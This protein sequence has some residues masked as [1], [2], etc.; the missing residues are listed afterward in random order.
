MNDAPAK[1]VEAVFGAAE[2][3]DDVF[4]AVND[5]SKANM[6]RRNA[7][8]KD[9]GLRICDAF[10]AARAGA[11][12]TTLYPKNAHLRKGDDKPLLEKVEG[13]VWEKVAPRVENKNQEKVRK[14]LKA[15]T[16]N[17]YQDE[18]RE[19]VIQADDNDDEED[20]PIAR[21]AR[22][23]RARPILPADE[24]DADEDDEDDPDASNAS[25]SDDDEEDDDEP[26]P[27]RQRG[28]RASIT[29][30]SSADPASRR[31]REARRRR[32]RA[33]RRVVSAARSRCRRAARVRAGR[34]V[35]IRR[36]HPVARSVHAGDGGRRG[37]G[38][39]CGD[40]GRRG[41]GGRCATSLAW[42]RA[43]GG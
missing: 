6:S 9:I 22:A 15:P 13:L 12:I 29:A 7:G 10:L 30:A 36:R 27:K 41:R 20:V 32:R 26:K 39:R 14:E 31:R 23:A 2:V 1:A 5:W 34:G 35:Q 33:L 42:P 18:I 16:R 19:N 43:T 38:G 40:G 3:G 11:G 21:R 17:G 37:R 8:L 25:S 24:A 4:A 28:R